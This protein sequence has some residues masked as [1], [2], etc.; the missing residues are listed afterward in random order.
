MAGTVSNSQSGLAIRLHYSV[1]Q[2]GSGLEVVKYLPELQELC[3]SDM[4]ADDNVCK[5]LLNCGH[6]GTAGLSNKIITDSGLNDLLRIDSFR[7]LQV[8]RSR[9]TKNGFAQVVEHPNGCRRN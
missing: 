2:T 8:S 4:S 7:S 9:I 3:A 6:L 1:M 5:S